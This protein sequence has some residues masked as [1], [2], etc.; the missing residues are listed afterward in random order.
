MKADKQMNMRNETDSLNNPE[1]QIISYTS[2]H[3]PLACQIG[4]PKKP[5]ITAHW[6][7]EIEILY[8]LEN[9]LTVRADKKTYL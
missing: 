4:L 8:I 6:H 9:S 2:K 5:D 1:K 7:E 3:L